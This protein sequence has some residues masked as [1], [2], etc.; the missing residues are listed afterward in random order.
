MLLALRIGEGMHWALT[1]ALTLLREIKS[2]ESH[3][4][5]NFTEFT[6][7][8]FKVLIEIPLKNS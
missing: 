4:Q 5:Y 3:H 1:A 8:H 7:T 6:I 2:E